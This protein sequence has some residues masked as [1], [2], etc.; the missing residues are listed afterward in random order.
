MV[1]IT[2]VENCPLV[3]SCVF[4]ILL[5]FSNANSIYSTINENVLNLV[6]AYILAT[7]PPINYI[8]EAICPRVIC[9]GEKGVCSPSLVCIRKEAVI[10]YTQLS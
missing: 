10:Y 4:F 2:I 5:K 7:E 8:V 6:A 1:S 3:S 9:V